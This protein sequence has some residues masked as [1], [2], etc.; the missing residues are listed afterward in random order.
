MR[1]TFNSFETHPN[2]LC[3]KWKDA[4]N[5]AIVDWEDEKVLFNIDP[6]GSSL[7]TIDTYYGFKDHYLGHTDLNPPHGVAVS[8]AAW[9]NRYYDLTWNY[10]DT[11]RRGIAAHEIGHTYFIGHIPESFYMNVLM[12]PGTNHYVWE[13]LAH[14]MEINNPTWYDVRL[15]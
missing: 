10:N 15:I 3:H 9:G 5:A 13:V 6:S 4:F 14:F 7:N 2:D 1:L 12:R 11:H 8:F